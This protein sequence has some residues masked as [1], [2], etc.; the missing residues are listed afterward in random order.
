[1]REAGSRE[2]SQP[3]P[4]HVVFEALA[5]PDRDPARPWLVLPD[6]EQAPAVL[7]SAPPARLV[8]SSLWVK[9]PDARIRF[10]LAAD[11]AGSRLRWTLLVDEPLPDAALLGHL[12]K[13]LNELINANLRYT[14]GQ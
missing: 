13:R 1:M 11:G 7:D 4:P 6:D 12:R 9:R 10:D 5:G 14:F 8:W 2:R 3:A